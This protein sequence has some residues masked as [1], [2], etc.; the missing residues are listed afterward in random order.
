M[1]RS[2]RRFAREPAHGGACSRRRLRRRARRGARLAPDASAGRPSRP[3]LRA[4]RSSPRRTSRST[5]WSVTARSRSRRFAARRSS[6][7]SGRRTVSPCKQEMP[8]LV[9]FAHTWS[10]RGVVVVGID[11]LEYRKGPARAFSR[12]YRRDLSDGVRPDRVDRRPVGRR[13][14]AAD[15]LRRSAWA[16]RRPCARPGHG[17]DARRPA[18]AALSRHEDRHRGRVA[19][20]GPGRPGARR[21][22]PERV[23]SRDQARLPGLPRDPR[24]VDRAGRG[25]DEDRDPPADRSGLERAADPRRDGRELRARAFSR[26]RPPTVSTCSR[27]CCRSAGSWSAR[28]GLGAGAWYWSRSRPSDPPAPVAALAPED[29]ARLDA[30]LARFDA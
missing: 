15:L 5:A 12:R 23:R 26:H 13:R 21:L 9:S 18:S 22:A 29:E 6:S 7:T 19:R 25:A 16:D 11:V 3:R 10:G 24:P 14:H 20:T 27:G 28:S 17:H 2:G 8:R 1:P 30:E 4:I